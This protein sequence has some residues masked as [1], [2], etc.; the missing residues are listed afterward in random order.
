MDTS[1][2]C[3][4]WAT[5]GT[6]SCKK[7][8]HTSGAGVLDGPSDLRC[9]F[10]GVLQSWLLLSLNG[11]LSFQKCIAAK[12]IKQSLGNKS[13]SFPTGKSDRYVQGGHS[14]GGPERSLRSLPDPLPLCPP[15]N[16]AGGRDDCWMPRPGPCLQFQSP[17]ALLSPHTFPASPQSR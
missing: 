12:K 8:S 9:V 17:S 15:E 14:Q 13:M 10:L 6:P 7:T 2:I 5:I 11:F 16:R 1:Q 3:F 4:H